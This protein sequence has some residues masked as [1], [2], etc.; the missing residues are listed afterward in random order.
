MTTK[1]AAEYLGISKY[2]LR[3]LRHGL[4]TYEGPKC[5]Q[6]KHPRGYAWYYTKED[7]DNWKKTHAFK[8]KTRNHQEDV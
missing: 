4:H 6:G 7:L 1:Q 3:N 2:Y 8:D 5:R